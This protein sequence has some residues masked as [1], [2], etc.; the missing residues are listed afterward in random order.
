M[1]HV[2]QAARGRNALQFNKAEPCTEKVTICLFK[3]PGM[4]K[5]LSSAQIQTAYGLGYGR[6]YSLSSW[7]GLPRRQL[8][9]AKTDE[10]G[11]YLVACRG[12]GILRYLSLA[13]F[14][15]MD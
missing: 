10:E 4:E 12:E 1:S 13:L 7:R 5:E 11:A 14:S 3:G 6:S 8:P 2:L 15:I 9:S